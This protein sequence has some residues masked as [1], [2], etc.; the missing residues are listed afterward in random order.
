MMENNDRVAFI[1]AFSPQ[2][3]KQILDG[4][5]PLKK[6][7]VRAENGGA[8]MELGQ[9]IFLDNGGID[10]QAINDISVDVQ[11]KLL[12]IRDMQIDAKVG[13]EQLKDNTMLMG[14]I[15]KHMYVMTFEGFSQVL[16]NLNIITNQI[17][18]FEAEYAANEESKRLEQFCKFKLSLNSAAD[19]L[20]EDEFSVSSAH[21]YITPILD[22]IA[23]FLDVGMHR[24]KANI[25]NKELLISSMIS[26][27]QPY[28]YVV[29]RYSAL[30]YLKKGHFPANN[31]NWIKPISTIKKTTGFYDHYH[32]ILRVNGNLPLPEAHSLTKHLQNQVFLQ[33]RQIETEKLYLPHINM[34]DYLNQE[35]FILRNYD[36]QHPIIIKNRLCIPML[37]SGSMELNG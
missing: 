35:E 2:N 25:G 10:L 33:I 31:D 1:F 32:Y 37:S 21:M 28:S 34:E 6:G 29:R 26:L 24:F 8:F 9:P 15:L 17:S 30:Y 27:I 36:P 12:S 5:L 3:T 20:C 14:T 11:S 16:Q 18:A 19:F 23:A 4:S 22:E 13:I 7:G